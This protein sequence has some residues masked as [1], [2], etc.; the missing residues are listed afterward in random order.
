[1]FTIKVWTYDSRLLKESN[2][3]VRQPRRAPHHVIQATT[4]ER[5]SHG[6][7]VAIRAKFE[8]ATFG[9][10]CTEHHHWATTPLWLYGFYITLSQ[11]RVKSELV[12]DVR[13]T[14]ASGRIDKLSRACN[15]FFIRSSNILPYTFIIN[16]YTFHILPRI[17]YPYRRHID[18][19]YAKLK[20]KPQRFAKV[21]DVQLCACCLAIP[22]QGPRVFISPFVLLS[23]SLSFWHYTNALSIQGFCGGTHLNCAA[24]TFCSKESYLISIKLKNSCSTLI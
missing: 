22:M 18:K 11:V 4:S 6:P 7:Y 10:E 9:F 3:T 8:P 16:W 1:M 17:K 13:R 20:L 23:L 2:V 12:Q 21:P 19:L 14:K 24:A 15:Y 5:L